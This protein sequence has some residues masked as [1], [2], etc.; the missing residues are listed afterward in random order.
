[1]FSYSLIWPMC[2]LATEQVY[3]GQIN[4]EWLG[5]VVFVVGSP[6]PIVVSK[7]PWAKYKDGLPSYI[8]RLLV[9][10]VFHSWHGSSGAVSPALLYTLGSENITGFTASKGREQVTHALIDTSLVASLSF[11]SSSEGY[12]LDKLY[13]FKYISCGF[14]LN[15]LLFWVF[16]TR[17]FYID[18]QEVGS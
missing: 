4:T 14:L 2:D 17:R 16:H 7:L 11:G 6:L 13:P 10:D 9:S 12:L 18:F 1:M 5:L 3:R 8:L 15:L